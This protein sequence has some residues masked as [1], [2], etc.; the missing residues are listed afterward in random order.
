MA[1]IG[2]GEDVTDRG[3][4]RLP[5]TTTCSASSTV[6]VTSRLVAAPA[7]TST[8][9]RTTAWK[10]GSVKATSYAPAVRPPIA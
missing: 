9:S 10:P 8:P 4:A 3:R 2:T 7:R 1:S 5:T 6:S